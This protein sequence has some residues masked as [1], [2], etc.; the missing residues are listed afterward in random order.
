MTELNYGT[1]QSPDMRRPEV[2]LLNRLAT[3][4]SLP[5]RT[6]TIEAQ[7][8]TTAPLPLLRLNGYDSK[9]YLPIAESRDWQAD[10]S[11]LT[12]MENPFPAS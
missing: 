6:V 1:T 4:Y 2:E 11:T 7:H 12:C 8:P 3:Y 9:H 5:R 10:K